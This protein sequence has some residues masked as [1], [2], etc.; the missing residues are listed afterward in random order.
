MPART[1]RWAI[2]ATVVCTALTA[3]GTNL[4]HDK[5]VAANGGLLGG[6][7]QTI[8][9]GGVAPT[10]G[11]NS[12]ATGAV[13]SAATTPGVTAG[14]T[15]GATSALTPGATSTGGTGGSGTGNTGG[16][17]AGAAGSGG[18]PGNVITAKCPSTGGDPIKLGNVGPYSATGAGPTTT[19]VRD[20]LNVWASYVNAHGGICGRQVQLLVRDDQGSAATSAATYKDLVEN[21]HVVAFVSGITPFTLTAFEPYLESKQVPMIGGDMLTGVYNRS[22]VFFPSGASDTETL[23][24]SYKSVQNQPSGTK[25]A[26]IYCI[27]VASCADN[28]KFQTQNHIPEM[29][30]SSIVY[31]K[32]VSLTQ[33]S[34]TAECQAAQKAGAGVIFAAGDGSFVERLANS[35]GQQGIKMSYLI[36]G[37]AALDSLTQ[38]QYLQG[39]GF[40]TTATVPWLATATAGGALYAQL[41]SQYHI[42]RSGAGA[43]ALVAALLMQQI[44]TELG[45]KPLTPAVILSQARTGVTN[46]TAGGMSGPL[47]FHDGAQ[48][49]D[50]CTGF[51]VIQSGGWANGN[52]GAL[53]C[54][55][56]PPGP[57]PTP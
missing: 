24:G 57:L 8:A 56:G 18:I 49:Q 45:N 47:T 13:T 4:A 17:T 51:A 15:P 39:H 16:A 10:V 34:F 30:G 2:L 48:P 7:T 26:F 55:N 38:N 14:S 32:Q 12:A 11:P 9:V 3:C 23:L 29:V 46:F 1:P 42:Q 37:A 44:L 19:P 33:I 52:G 22:P 40:T 20:I 21:Q 50:Q 54:R 41:A 43:T 35:C 27:E 25:V 28:Y 36:A 53:S 5:I 31:A 6:A